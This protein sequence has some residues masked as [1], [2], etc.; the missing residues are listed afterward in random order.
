VE[1]ITT[2]K[3]VDQRVDGGVSRTQ[4][5]LLT[6]REAIDLLGFGKQIS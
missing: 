3:G 2:R 4:P 6:T 1:R 5:S